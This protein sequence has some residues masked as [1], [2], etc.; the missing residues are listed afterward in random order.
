MAYATVEDLEEYL[1]KDAPDKAE[2]LL[3]RATELI[4]YYTLDRAGRIITALVPQEYDEWEK[5]VDY[6][7]GD[8]VEYEEDHYICVLNHKATPNTEPPNVLYWAEFEPE[9]VEKEILAFE[10][11]ARLAVCAQV[12]YW[13]ST[14]DEFG[15]LG[16]LAS[17]SIGSQSISVGQ[18]AEEGLTELA[19]RARQALTRFGLFYRGVSSR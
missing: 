14:G 1:G 12:E 13:L 11:P 10:G 5:N 2:R 6:L 17:Y 8:V 15:F 19:P 7:E 18:A 9:E 16:R 4:N 3:E